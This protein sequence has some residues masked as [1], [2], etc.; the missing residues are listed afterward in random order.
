MEAHDV[1][2]GI[3]EAVVPAYNDCRLILEH[4]VFDIRTGKAA[5][6]SEPHADVFVESLQPIACDAVFEYVRCRRRALALAPGSVAQRERELALVASQRPVFVA[7]HPW[8]VITRTE[9]FE[10]PCDVCVAEGDI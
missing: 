9:V 3:D 6:L 8:V 1:P 5:S 2:I 10:A 4:A 7:A